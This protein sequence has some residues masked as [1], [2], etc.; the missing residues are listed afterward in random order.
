[1]LSDGKINVSIK[2]TQAMNP[3][4]TMEEKPYGGE[5]NAIESAIT[6]QTDNA[7]F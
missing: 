2:S 5:K 4:K 6:N 7:R 3:E 1:M